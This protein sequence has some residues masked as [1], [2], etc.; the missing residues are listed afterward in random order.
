ME[1]LTVGQENGRREG[2]ERSIENLYKNHSIALAEKKVLTP[3][4]SM[5]REEE[6]GLEFVKEYS[7]QLQDKNNHVQSC[8]S[9]AG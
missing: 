5:R 2:Q 3:H 8:F 9:Q 6:G 1:K 7:L 4:S